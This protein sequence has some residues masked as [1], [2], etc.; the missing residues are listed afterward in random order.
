M[1]KKVIKLIWIPKGK[2]KYAF[3][4]FVSFGVHCGWC[5]KPNQR[6]IDTIDNLCSPFRSQL[7]RSRV[8]ICVRAPLNCAGIAFSFIPTEASINGT[9]LQARERERRR[10]NCQLP[11]L[12]APFHINCRAAR[13]DQITT[14]ITLLKP[15][16][17]LTFE[18]LRGPDKGGGT[19]PLGLATCAP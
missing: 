7:S 13:S 10:F 4:P 18:T 1:K 6:M 17:P 11:N 14:L 12:S 19:R 9:R 8:D 15:P 2:R 16:P 3:F 5:P